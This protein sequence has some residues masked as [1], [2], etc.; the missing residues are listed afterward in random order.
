MR[1]EAAASAAVRRWP[2]EVGLFV[3]MAW[4]RTLSCVGGKVVGS[5]DASRQG[6]LDGM[7]GRGP[8]IWCGVRGLGAVVLSSAGCG[9]LYRAAL[10]LEGERWHVGA[11][12]PDVVQRS[13]SACGCP[14]QCGLRATVS[15]GVAA[16]GERWHVGAAALEGGVG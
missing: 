11:A 12:G 13:W 2:Q 6:R 15:C 1:A 3:G 14:E 10:L 4:A 5:V 9:L 8:W 16:R 7:S